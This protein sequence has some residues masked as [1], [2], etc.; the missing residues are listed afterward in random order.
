MPDDDVNIGSRQAAIETVYGGMTRWK[1]RPAHVVAAIV[2]S[3][4]VVASRGGAQPALPDSLPTAEPFTTSTPWTISRTPEPVADGVESSVRSSDGITSP[5]TPM[6]G[7]PSTDTTATLLPPATASPLA[8][9]L[10]PNR[11]RIPSLGIDAAIQWVGVDSEGRMGVP[12]NYTDV[13]W[14]ED[15]PAP[16]TRGNAVLAGHFDSTTGPAVFYHLGDLKPGDEIVTA[17]ADGQEYRFIVIDSEVYDTDEAPLE[18]IF[19]PADRPYL[20][21]ITCDGVFDRSLRQYDQRLV[22]YST[23]APGP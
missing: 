21:L 12:S 5:P 8:Q 2:L 13:A 1:V 3:V 4:I 16:G 18:R 15:G 10:G 20:N 22:V 23:L 7:S 17:T 14:Y 11:L 9:Q 19:G 6:S